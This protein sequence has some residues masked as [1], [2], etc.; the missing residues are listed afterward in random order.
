MTIRYIKDYSK[1]IDKDNDIFYLNW[2][3]KRISNKGEKIYS[4]SIRLYNKYYIEKKYNMSKN[5][6]KYIFISF[7]INRQS[8][9]NTKRI[10]DTIN[11]WKNNYNIDITKYINDILTIEYDNINL[12]D[13]L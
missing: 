4:I 8:E 9:Y 13:Y 12:K 11:Y 6:I 10:N 1:D 5:D 2:I 3:N 7:D